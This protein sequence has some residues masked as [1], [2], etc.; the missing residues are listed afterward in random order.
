MAHEHLA[1]VGIYRGDLAFAAKQA[2][3]SGHRIRVQI[4]HFLCGPWGITIE[5]AR[6]LYRQRNEA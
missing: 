5:A 1:W 6:A 4:L 3:A 2:I